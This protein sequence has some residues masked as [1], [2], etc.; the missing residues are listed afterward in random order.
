MVFIILITS[1]P[2]SVPATSTCLTKIA[3]LSVM[4]LLVSGHLQHGQHHHVPVLVP[5]QPHHGCVLLADVLY[6]DKLV[7]V[8][9]GLDTYISQ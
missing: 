1:L 3:V 6:E 8:G 5:S 4:D 7:L 2:N 9:A